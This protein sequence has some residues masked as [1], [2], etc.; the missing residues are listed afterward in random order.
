MTTTEIPEEFQIPEEYITETQEAMQGGGVQ[1]PFPVV[2]FWWVNG[3]K[4]DAQIGGVRYFGGWACDYEKMQDVSAA[5]G[6]PVPAGLEM[7]ELVN[8]DGVFYNAYVSRFLSIAP[9]ASRRRW[10]KQTKYGDDERGR[11]HTQWLCWLGSYDKEAGVYLPWG[12]AVLTSKGLASK[13]IW[14][15]VTDF[16]MKT[17]GARREFANN[18][19]AWF[20]YHPIGTFGEKPNFQEVGTQYKNTITPATAYVPAEITRENLLKWY[21]GKDI[22]ERVHQL[23][24]DAKPWLETWDKDKEAGDDITPETFSQAPA[25]PAPQHYD[26][27]LPP[28]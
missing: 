21:I 22:V 28:F 8:D 2:Y 5:I 10:I 24:L 15:A 23:R 20:F 18:L 25:E 26:E 27:G 1:L 14:D 16:G 6:S 3:E 13:A 11:S 17:G 12:T 19:P 7:T 9:I 4:R